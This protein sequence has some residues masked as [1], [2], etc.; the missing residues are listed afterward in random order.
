MRARLAGL[1]VAGVLIGSLHGCG[2]GV[3]RYETARV[4]A[5]DARA[6]AGGAPDVA[7]SDVPSGGDVAIDVASGADQRA[8]QAADGV[9]AP[10]DA[11]API[12]SGTTCTTQTVILGRGGT[13]SSCSFKVSASIP[14]DQVNLS[15]GGGRLCQQ[16]SNNCT[17]RGG[18]FWFGDDVAL[19]DATCLSWEASRANLILEV[20]CASESCFVA[21]RQAGGPCGDGVNSCC[22]GWRCTGGTCA[23]CTRGGQA[24]TTTAEC[25]SGD[26]PERIVCRRPGRHLRFAGRLLP[27]RVPRRALP[28]RRRSDPVQRAAA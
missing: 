1:A 24:C 22:A 13:T 14:R 27:G 25:C 9:D 8:D 23:A 17:S 15:L 18:W 4:D 10:V 5:R 11:T 21:C 7:G 3:V 16:G 12:D 19:C 28:V 2:G 6:D 20:G 26:V